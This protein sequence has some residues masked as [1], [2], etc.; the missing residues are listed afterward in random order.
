MRCFAVFFAAQFGISL[1]SRLDSQ[2]L[3]FNHCRKPTSSAKISSETASS[4][5]LCCLP[6]K[7]VQG[8]PA[9]APGCCAKRNK[10]LRKWR[11]SGEI[12]YRFG[13]VFQ[14]K[15][16]DEKTAFLEAGFL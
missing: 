16:F 9:A 11:F 8:G 13:E 15:N 12:A 7:Q 1:K 5:S 10:S 4:Q 3:F 6:D 2:T 14:T